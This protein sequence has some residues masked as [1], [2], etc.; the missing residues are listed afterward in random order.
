MDD[1]ADPIPSSLLDALLV[2]KGSLEERGSILVRRDRKMSHRLRVRAYT[3][4]G[5]RRQLSIPIPEQ[6]VPAVNELLS[7]WR[8]E[9]RAKVA[10]KQAMVDEEKAR[11]RQERLEAREERAALRLMI[12]GTEW[13]RRSFLREWDQVNKLGLL[14]STVWLATRQYARPCPPKGKRLKPDKAA[15]AKR[16]GL[17]QTVDVQQVVREKI[18]QRR[19]ELALA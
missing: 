1:T 18:Q 10:A 15:E 2:L 11:K 5:F 3:A 16:L 17:F 7:Q 13:H 12:G 6:C 8:A 14:Q 19:R 4:E 9:Y